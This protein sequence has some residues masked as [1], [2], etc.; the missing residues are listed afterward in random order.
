MPGSV[1][2]PD[3]VHQSAGKSAIK[4]GVKAKSKEHL[5]PIS[6]S[7]TRSINSARHVSMEEG[8]YQEA[9]QSE[10]KMVIKKVYRERPIR[11]SGNL[12]REI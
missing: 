6:T 2:R 11:I 9:H 3:L 1:R 12:V 10:K 4:K 5:G 8:T 7:T